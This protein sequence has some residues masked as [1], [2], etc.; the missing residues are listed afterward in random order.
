MS[1]RTWPVM[2]WYLA[3][4]AEL[5]QP[6]IPMAARSEMTGQEDGFEDALTERGHVMLVDPDPS[7]AYWDDNSL[8]EIQRRLPRLAVMFPASDTSSLDHVLG[9]SGRRS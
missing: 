8:A 4:I 3:A 7:D 1:R 6:M 5:D 2:C 9:E